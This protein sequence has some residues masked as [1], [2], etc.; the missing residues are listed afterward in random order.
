[1]VPTTIFRKIVVARHDANRG[2]PCLHRPRCLAPGLATSPA[3]PSDR[4]QPRC[5]IAD[6]RC[7]EP[8]RSASVG[9]VR[10]TRNSTI[11]RAAASALAAVGVLALA[12]AALAS[13]A[14]FGGR[15]LDAVHRGNVSFNGLD[16][17][18]RVTKV[19]RFS[20]NDVPVMCDQGKFHLTPG[21]FGFAMKVLATSNAATNR[22]FKGSASLNG[23]RFNIYV[24][25]HFNQSFT[26]TQGNFEARGDYS[27]Q[28]TGCDTGELHWTARRR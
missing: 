27:S 26:K 10:S 20:W 23:D 17:S 4:A 6:P 12:S 15:F 25:G 14:H 9:A 22:T 21:R 7:E 16:T 3:Q 8:R 5:H 2:A 28:A 11:A 13:T 24:A 1:M 18:G 19:A